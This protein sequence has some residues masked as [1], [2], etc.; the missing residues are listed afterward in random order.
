MLLSCLF[1]VLTTHFNQTYRTQCAVDVNAPVEMADR[2]INQLVY[3]FQ[4]D[5]EHLFDWAFLNLGK[6]QDDN[7]DALLLESRSITYNP[8]MEYG[9]IVLDVIIPKFIT[10][11]NISIDG[12]IRD[13]RR[14]QLFDSLR[15][16]DGLIMDSIHIWSRHM[17]IEANKAGVIFEKAYGN[18]YIIPTAEDHSI[19]F[20]DINF[21][22]NW[23]LQ[24]F[25]SMKT[26]KNTIQWRVEK[27]MKNL[28]HAAEQPDFMR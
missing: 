11:P 4:Y 7:R 14:E 26:Y 24:M 5:F 23:F 6:Q 21:R 3:D 22:F 10:I 19:Y 9:K 27:Y 18:L 13:E 28:K 1:F 17:Y 15:T 8:D 25:I 20:M 2:V 16:S 12:V